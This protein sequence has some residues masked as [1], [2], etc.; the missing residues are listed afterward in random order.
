MR[1]GLVMIHA[2]EPLWAVVDRRQYVRGR[3]ELHRSAVDAGL[4][5]NTKWHGEWRASAAQIAQARA[6]KKPTWR[7]WHFVKDALVAADV[8]QSRPA[9]SWAK[10]AGDELCTKYGFTKLRTRN[11]YAAPVGAVIVYGG[12]DAGHVEFRTANGFASDSDGS[13][14]GQRAE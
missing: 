12:A 6:F 10:Q 5:V 1:L 4:K 11:P 13:G 9:T 14:P 2:S 7:C 8:V 3:R